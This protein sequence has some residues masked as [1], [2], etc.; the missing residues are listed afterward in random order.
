MLTCQRSR[1][2]TIGCLFQENASIFVCVFSSEHAEKLADRR[3]TKA[4]DRTSHPPGRA[5]SATATKR[6]QLANISKASTRPRRSIGLW[7]DHELLRKHLSPKR[8]RFFL[9]EGSELAVSNRY[10]QLA[11]M[12]LQHAEKRRTKQPI[13]LKRKAA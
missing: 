13:E 1:S 4:A 2:L 6:K 3:A 8:P 9:P 11:D 12:L 10:L 5:M 7:V